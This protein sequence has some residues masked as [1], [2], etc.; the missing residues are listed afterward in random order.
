LF[1]SCLCLQIFF[2]QVLW[3]CWGNLHLWFWWGFFHLWFCWLFF[4][5]NLFLAL[6]LAGLQV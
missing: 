3:L 2:S 1:S 4:R 6:T 5:G